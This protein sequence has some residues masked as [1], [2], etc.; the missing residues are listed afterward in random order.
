MSL[1]KTVKVAL[2]FF[3]IKRDEKFTLEEFIQ[4]VKSKCGTT[5][6]DLQRDI[7]DWFWLLV[8]IGLI[9]NT[10]DNKFYVVKSDELM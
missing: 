3:S 9:G 5:R 7:E 10:N 1:A 4:Y 8:D 6:I 2:E